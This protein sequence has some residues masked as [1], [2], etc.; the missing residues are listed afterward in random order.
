MEVG[1][2][3]NIDP[4]TTSSKE[5]IHTCELT[6]FTVTRKYDGL[7]MVETTEF[8]NLTNFNIYSM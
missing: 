1:K 7:E 5:T 2:L 6:S 4:L 8:L 3:V